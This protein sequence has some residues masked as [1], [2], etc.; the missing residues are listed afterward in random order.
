MCTIFSVLAFC[1]NSSSIRGQ[2]V[3]CLMPQHYHTSPI[4]IRKEEDRD[5]LFTAETH[6]FPTGF[7][8]VC[9]YALVSLFS[10]LYSSS[11]FTDFPP[12]R[13]PSPIPCALS[14]CSSFKESHRSLARRRV[15]EGA[16]VTFMLRDVAL[17]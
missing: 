2:S 8:G 5:V 3:T 10:T 16:F 12:H 17:S 6:N 4:F 15:W 13:P 7:I 14:D 11:P 9:V 1:D